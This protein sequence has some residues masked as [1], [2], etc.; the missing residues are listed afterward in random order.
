MSET[1]AAIVFAFIIALAAFV[2]QARS[3]PYVQGS[4]GCIWS[5]QQS[6]DDEI[7]F[8][9][10]CGA[11]GAVEGGY[12]FETPYLDVELGLEAAL[13]VK[14]LHGRNAFDE[15]SADG[16]TLSAYSALAGVRLV[17]EIYAP[18]SIYAQGA[19]GGALVEGLGDRT[20]AP[21][22]QVEGGLRIDVWESLSVNAGYR[23]FQVLGVELDGNRGDLDFHGAVIGLRWMFQ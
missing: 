8:G 3:E 20:L 17:R 23:Y 9:A 11:L 4:G 14:D 16:H 21:A 10:E 15:L 6:N 12:V 19:G 13:R 7:E 2:G 5:G 18:V 22:W 1:T